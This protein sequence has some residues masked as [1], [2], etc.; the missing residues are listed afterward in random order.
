MQQTLLLVRHAN[1][2]DNAPT[3]ALR[4]LSPKGR[5]QMSRLAKG[6]RGKN[7]VNPQRI[8]HS[9]LA[10]AYET[11]LALK[12]GLDLSAQLIEKDGLSPFDDPA[13]IA[14]RLKT[15]GDDV[16]VVGHQ[17]HLSG[18]ASLLLTDSDDFHNVVFRK[19]S[20]LC[21]HRL[22]TGNQTTR[23]QIEWHLC[24]KHF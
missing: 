16:M 8:W 13:I 22:N 3:D 4:P 24:H 12:E 7:L 5:K 6:L 11:A 17:P 2:L 19:A 21:L 23:W 14:A 15:I 10:R 18:L 9:G 20:I 1:A